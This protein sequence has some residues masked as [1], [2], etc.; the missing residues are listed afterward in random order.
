MKPKPPIEKKPV[1]VSESKGRPERGTSEPQRVRQVSQ[2]KNAQDKKALPK[3]QKVEERANNAQRI[4]TQEKKGPPKVHKEEKETKKVPKESSQEKKVTHD[5]QQS[6][7][8]KREK[9]SVREQA[10]SKENDAE[11][12]EKK[13]KN[14]KKEKKQ[15]EAKG[16]NDTNADINIPHEPKRRK[17]SPKAKTEESRASKLVDKHMKNI[18]L[19]QVKDE[20]KD[21]GGA[22]SFT[23]RESTKRVKAKEQPSLVSR[24]TEPINRKLTRSSSENSLEEKKAIE[25]TE[26]H[27]YT[28]MKRSRSPD[29]DYLG[30]IKHAR[31]VHEHQRETQKPD[32]DLKSTKTPPALVFDT[33]ALPDLLGDADMGEYQK[34][35]CFMQIP[36]VPMLKRGTGKHFCLANPRKI[37][38]WDKSVNLQMTKNVQMFQLQKDPPKLLEEPE[39]RSRPKDIK[40]IRV[41]P[42]DLSYVDREVVIKEDRPVS[43]RV[44]AK[45]MLESRLPSSFPYIDDRCFTGRSIKR[46]K[47]PVKIINP[48]Q[49][50]QSYRNLAAIFNK[51]RRQA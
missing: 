33:S 29:Y 6:Q 22:P 42:L 13:K 9:Q 31:T 32:I 30:R 20:E 5:P 44:A 34:L 23:T 49:T 18:G 37:R 38:D 39:F 19:A 7:A 41:P 17:E 43:C 47:T 46:S 40:T 11:A 24:A 2:E 26:F 48:G 8:Q 21:K 27:Y 14:A 45:K 1:N 51:V 28:P 16:T 3:A 4:G 15:K 25:K 35:S 10:A 12:H 50:K 36:E